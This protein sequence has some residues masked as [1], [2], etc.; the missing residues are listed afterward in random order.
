MHEFAMQVDSLVDVDPDARL[1]LL[2]NP[3]A[4]LLDEKGIELTG[5]TLWTVD[6]TVENTPDLVW[7]SHS[8]YI[9]ENELYLVAFVFTGGEKSILIRT[10]SSAPAGAGIEIPLFEQALTILGD[11]P[12]DVLA[13]WRRLSF[14]ANLPGESALEAGLMSNARET[15]VYQGIGFSG[16]LGE[17]HVIDH[18]LGKEVG[19]VWIEDPEFGQ[20]RRPEAFAVIGESC[21]VVL[22]DEI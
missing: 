12:E 14:E 3:K 7:R 4:W 18:I 6:L 16:L 21:F 10:E 8:Q 20:L 15:L 17:I 1:D 5:S 9:G 11:Y 2:M 22:N 19:A 13:G